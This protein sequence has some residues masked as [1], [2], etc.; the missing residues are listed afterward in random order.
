[1]LSGRGA[2]IEEVL[3]DRGNTRVRFAELL[4]YYGQVDR[5]ILEH[6]PF[7]VVKLELLST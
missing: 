7:C 4:D 1:V 3:D 6:A 5:A 2:T